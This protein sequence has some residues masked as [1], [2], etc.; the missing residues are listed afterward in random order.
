AFKR[1]IQAK[2]NVVTLNSLS[3]LLKLEDIDEFLAS[4]QLRDYFIS[5]DFSRA[6]TNYLIVEKS[7]VE[8]IYISDAI[9]NT[10]LLNVKNYGAELNFPSPS[11]ISDMEVSDF[12]LISDSEFTADISFKTLASL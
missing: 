2:E 1:G 4:E 9:E 3:D 12:Y 5:D 8:E 11:D 6:L 7:K 10:A